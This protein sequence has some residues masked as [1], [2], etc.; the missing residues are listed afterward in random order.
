MITPPRP[1]VLVAVWTACLLGACAGAPSADETS[2][3]EGIA[4]GSTAPRTDREVS[5]A[6]AD[7]TVRVETATQRPI[8]DH[9]GIPVPAGSATSRALRAGPTAEDEDAEGGEGEGEA[10][11]GEGEGEGEIADEGGEEAA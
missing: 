6:P 2:I 7:R 8:R 5:R 4:P 11:D 9:V 1:I 10:I 3:P